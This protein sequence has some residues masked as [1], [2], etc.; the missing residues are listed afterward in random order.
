MIFIV[1]RGVEIYFLLLI[2]FS[3]ISNNLA[4]FIPPAVENAVPPISITTI[5]NILPLID[6]WDKLNF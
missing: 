3:K 1:K 6:R 4:I 5:S 2:N